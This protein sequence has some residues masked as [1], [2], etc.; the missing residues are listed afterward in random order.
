MTESA[1]AAGAFSQVECRPRKFSP[2]PVA[3]RQHVA[4]NV[5]TNPAS[6]VTTTS[7]TN[8]AAS[9]ANSGSAFACSTMPTPRKPRQK[10]IEHANRSCYTPNASNNT[11]P[12][13]QQHTQHSTIH[14]FERV[15]QAEKK[16]T[17]RC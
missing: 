17:T 15:E 8:N 16:V 9:H 6:L 10:S 11:H 5:S 4:V 7:S 14:M 2:A 12:Y 13:Q 3:R 1:A